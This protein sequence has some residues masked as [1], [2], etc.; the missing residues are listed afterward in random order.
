MISPREW[1]H[2]Y[3]PISRESVYIGDNHAFEIIDIG[4]VKINMFNGMVR[5]IEK[6]RHVKDLKNISCL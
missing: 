2:K 6:V 3:E 4:T 5:T 1:F